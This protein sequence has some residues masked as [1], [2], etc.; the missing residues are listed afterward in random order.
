MGMLAAGVN[1]IKLAKDDYVIA[2]ERIT[3]GSEI[4]L[5]ADDGRG[6]RFSVDEIPV[7]GRYGQGVIATRLKKGVELA[8]M[9]LGKGSQVGIVH[10]HSSASRTMRLDEISQLKRSVVGK[11]VLPVKPGDEVYFVTPILDNLAIWKQK[12]ELPRRRGKAKGE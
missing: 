8:G 12:E 10:F 7:Q 11:E 3:A 1:G 5:L 4:G 6:L 9:L 2:A